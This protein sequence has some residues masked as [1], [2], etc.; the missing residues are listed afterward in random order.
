MHSASYQIKYHSGG[1]SK[2]CGE[3]PTHPHVSFTA[4]VHRIGKKFIF[5]TVL[6]ANRDDHNEL[7]NAMFSL[8]FFH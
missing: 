2:I 4:R 8:V 3:L 7:I 5:S 1:I 6:F